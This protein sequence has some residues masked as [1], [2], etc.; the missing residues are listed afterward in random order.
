MPF[1]VRITFAAERDVDEILAWLVER[2]P[3]TAARWH[4]AL[5][6]KV[7]SLESNPHRY[8]LA[9][10]AERLKIGL[11][12]MHFGRR[13][14]VFRILFTI[15]GEVVTVHHIRRG[16]RDWLKRGDL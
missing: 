5:L 14:N 12:E 7:Q 1:L 2:A 13:R 9:V 10:E 16:S 15:D 4:G 8:P 6:K 3:L 11:R